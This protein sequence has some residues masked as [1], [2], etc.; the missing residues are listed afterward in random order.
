[1][2]KRKKGGEQTLSILLKGGKGG[3]KGGKLHTFHTFH[4]FILIKI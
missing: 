3:R 1:M 2:Q 4:T